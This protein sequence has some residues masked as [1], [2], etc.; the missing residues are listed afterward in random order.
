MKNLFIPTASYQPE[1]NEKRNDRYEYLTLS[2]DSNASTVSSV[3]GLQ[4]AKNKH[5]NNRI[6]VATRYLE[7][8]RTT[9]TTDFTLFIL[10]ESN[11]GSCEGK[12]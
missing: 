7:N 10:E 5:E 4:R 6:D 11:A 3:S 2:I 12:N 9:R 8:L 1:E